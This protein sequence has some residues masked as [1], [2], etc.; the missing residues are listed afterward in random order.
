MDQQKDSDHMEEGGMKRSE[1]ERA[2]N[3]SSP[4]RSRAIHD[5]EKQLQ[6]EY[7]QL[8]SISGDI[9]KRK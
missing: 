1:V 3:D 4:S 9:R 5:L 7:G 8:E 2:A 6:D